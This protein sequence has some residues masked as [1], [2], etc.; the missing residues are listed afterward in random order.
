MGSGSS[1]TTT[2]NTAPWSGQQPY[3]TDL[4]Q[5]GQNLYQQGPQQY[6]PGQ[7]VAA[8]SPQTQ[9]G[10]DANMQRAMSGDPS[11]SAF[12][13][14]LTGALGMQNFNP[15]SIGAGGYQ[16]MG[17]IGSGMD[18]LGQAGAPMSWQQAQQMAG[19]VQPGTMDASQ[20]FVRNALGSI[21]P[22]F[23]NTF[24]SIQSMLPGAADVSGINTNFGMNQGAAGQLGSTAGGNYLGSNPYLDQVY[25]TAAGKLTNNF[26]ESIMPSIAAQ[27]GASGRTGS[28]LHQLSAGRAAGELTD[29]LA[30]LG[31]DVYAP[32]YESERNRQLQAAGQLG[33]LGLGTN[34]L[35][36]GAQIAKARL[37]QE[38]GALGLN[39]AT[40]IYGMD[41]GQQL[42][43]AQLG[44]DLFSSLNNA[45]YSRAALGSQLYGQG[46][47][48]ML[49][50]GSAL[51]SLGMQGM[52]NLA[53]LYGDIGDQQ[54]RAGSLAPS[55]QAMQYGDIDRM[56]Q[57]G[58]MIEDQAQRLIDADV[59]RWNFGQSAPWQNLGNYANLIY[60]LPGGYGTTTQT[61]P[62]G[63]RLAGAA[64][65]AMSG[66]ALGP[67][68][69]LG[70]AVLGGLL[71]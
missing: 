50:A 71:A 32:A 18:M 1:K 13:N 28:G 39:A 38:G 58:G 48:R 46:L 12:G 15:Y 66:A 63:S 40:N 47:D 7:T 14:Y 27:F 26:N 49:G 52:Q 23:Q 43:A 61:Q 69:A 24:Q 8:F 35:N 30:Q 3:L 41:L 70:G 11:Q 59:N 51:G 53:G 55:Y 6:F 4:F 62:G 22:N 56:L 37:G 25:D 33:N 21:N 29:S 65:G 19:S 64:G 42:G 34:Q 36:S 5:Q 60:G 44:G 68:G 54:F 45:D 20:Q 10:L 31:A 57:S 9:M 67:W 17:G 16:A 2:T